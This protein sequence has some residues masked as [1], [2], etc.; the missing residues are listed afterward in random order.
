MGV[1]FLQS[2]TDVPVP[3]PIGIVIELPFTVAQQVVQA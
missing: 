1:E 2:L 3:P